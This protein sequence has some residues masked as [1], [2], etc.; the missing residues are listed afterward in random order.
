MVLWNRK[1]KKKLLG[2]KRKMRNVYGSK[3]KWKTRTSIFCFRPKGKNTPRRSRT[4]A[5]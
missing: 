4:G 1:K 3:S 2:N 5:I